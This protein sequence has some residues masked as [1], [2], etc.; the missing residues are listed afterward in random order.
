MHSC[1]HRRSD[2][3]GVGIVSSSTFN[4]ISRWK[5]RIKSLDQLRVAGKQLADPSDHTGSIDGTA[6]EVFHDI[7]EAVVDIGMVG[8]LNLDLVEIAQSIVQDRLL[9]LCLALSLTLALGAHLL[10][11]RGLRLAL[12][13]RHEQSRRV[14]L[15]LSLSGL[16]WSTSKHAI[17]TGWAAHLE[18]SLWLRSS[19]TWVSKQAIW[20][21]NSTWSDSHGL[22]QM[23][24]LTLSLMLRR[25]FQSLALLLAMLPVLLFFDVNLF[26]FA[27]A[28]AICR[29][30]LTSRL[31]E[32]WQREVWALWTL[33]SVC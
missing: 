23:H 14:A 32:S 12:R 24:G 31:A 16:N 9:T 19:K 29:S 2:P 15:V 10:L 5:E 20:T 21:M 30:S 13:K 7:Q 3:D 18:L 8:E 33:R 28:F 1:A 22:V 17:R 26:D 4:A 27:S 11:L 6:L 25:L